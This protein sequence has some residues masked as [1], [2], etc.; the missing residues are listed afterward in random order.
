MD[1]KEALSKV[2]SSG[3]ANKENTLKECE[4]RLE[5]TRNIWNIIVILAFVLAAAARIVKYLYGLDRLAA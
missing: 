4:S 2:Q 5:K 1:Y 3:T